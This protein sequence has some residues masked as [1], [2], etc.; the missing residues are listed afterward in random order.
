[1][2]PSVRICHDIFSGKSGEENRFEVWP[3]ATRFKPMA[4]VYVV[5][6][7]E[8]TTGTFQRAEHEQIYLGHTTD[9]S[10]PLGTQA[11]LAGFDA[12]GANCVCLYPVES[13]E[14]RAAI[15]KDLEDVGVH[16]RSLVL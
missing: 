12:S 8:V 1:M 16:Y 6:R 4:A 3:I 5:T 13:A 7:R 11:Q 2:H 15:K 10:G 9:I 14:R